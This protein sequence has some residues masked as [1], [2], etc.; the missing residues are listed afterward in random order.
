MILTVLSS[1]SEKVVISW[2]G[3]ARVQ[4]KRLVVHEHLAVT[5]PNPKLR[6]GV[7][8]LATQE[9]F[10]FVVL[11]HNMPYR[12]DFFFFAFALMMR[13]VTLLL[14]SAPLHRSGF[15]VFEDEKEG[16]VCFGS[17]FK[18][19]WCGLHEAAAKGLVCWDSAEGAW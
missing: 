10:D 3:N 17:G 13:T 7:A 15:S 14:P 2:L 12:E 5:H 19:C 1:G 11:R 4:L 16:S 6:I 18:W 9:A 8:F